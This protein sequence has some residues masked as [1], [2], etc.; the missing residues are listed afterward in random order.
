M[1]E[2]EIGRSI[3]DILTVQSG[4]RL[5]IPKETVRALGI[6]IGDLVFVEI[7]KAK[8]VKLGLEKEGQKT[9]EE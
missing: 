4:Y 9:E 3:E 8:V 2:D 7:T 1:E 6:E 5:G